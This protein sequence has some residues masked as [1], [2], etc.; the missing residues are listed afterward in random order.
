MQRC[1]EKKVTKKSFVGNG[2][3]SHTVARILPSA[4]ADLTAGFGMEPGVPP[5]LLSPT[6]L[7]FYDMFLST[8]LAWYTKDWIGLGI[9][10][11]NDYGVD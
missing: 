3:L 4:L 1:S 8:A 2:L 11:N 7:F 10:K 9:S 6:K 5:P